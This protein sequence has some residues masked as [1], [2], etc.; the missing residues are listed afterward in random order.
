MKT[1]NIALCASLIYSGVAHTATAQDLQNSCAATAPYPKNHLY[2]KQGS[3]SRRFYISNSL[4][5]DCQRAVY[6]AA[7]NWNNSTV[8]AG[9]VW[10]GNVANDA[11]L[12]DPAAGSDMLVQTQYNTP[13][14]WAGG[15][16]GFEDAYL[17][18]ATQRLTTNIKYTTNPP[19]VGRDGD[20][21]MNAKRLAE[22]HCY[23]T[24]TPTTKRDMTSHVLHEIGHIWGLDHDDCDTTADDSLKAVMWWQG[25]KGPTGQKRTLKPRDIARAQA[26]YGAK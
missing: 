18:G 17:W 15:S 19:Y 13:D 23:S 9:L 7:I 1:V 25:F 20:Y 26:I 12:A 16:A 10:S 8:N 14:T 2:L 6:D 4:P 22:F 11:W 24:S 3:V 5:T 21:V